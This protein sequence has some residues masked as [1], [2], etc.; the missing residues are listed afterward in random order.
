MAWHGYCGITERVVYH[1]VENDKFCTTD[2]VIGELPL[3]K[4]MEL[5]FHFDFGDDCRFQL[6]VESISRNIL[7]VQSQQSLNNMATHQSNILT[8]NYDGDAQNV[9]DGARA[10]QP[11]LAAVGH[12]ETFASF[13]GMAG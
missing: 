2:C 10:D 9:S 1:Y 8:G 5:I 7:V 6:V 13:Q 11:R 12:Q 4:G 3:Y